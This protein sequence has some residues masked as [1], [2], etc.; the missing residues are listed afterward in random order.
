METHTQPTSAPGKSISEKRAIVI[1]EAKLIYVEVAR[2][3]CTSI[4]QALGEAFNRS[5]EEILTW[6]G[7]KMPIVDLRDPKYDDYFRF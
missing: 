3:A 4:K 7:G 2:V 5:E 6:R 1:D